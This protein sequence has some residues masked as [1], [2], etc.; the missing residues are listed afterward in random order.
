MLIANKLGVGVLMA[1]A[2]LGAQAEE[3]LVLSAAAVK[4]SIQG[5]PALL[6]AQ[7]PDS[8]QLRFGTAGAMRDEAI[9]GAAFDI[10]VVPPPAM[11]E[12]VKR[13]LVDPATQRPLGAVRLAAGLAAGRPVP[14]LSDLEAFKRSLL[15][16]N[17]VGIADP[18]KGAT[19]GIYLA[20]LFD[21]LG[22]AE[23]MKTRLRFYPEG[24]LAMEAA[25]A[26]EIDMA[27]GQMSEGSTVPGLSPLALLPDAVQLRTVYVA[28]LAQ[29]AP[30]PQTARKAMDLMLSP[31]VQQTFRRNGFDAVAQP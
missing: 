13:G 30:H 8:A 1:L 27:I 25:A 9:A 6:A 21:K 14:D 23:A 18:A 20:G 26:K 24:Q 7:G 5:V 2:A 15:Q 3:V 10:V 28:A 17:S 4:T 19:T 16:A 22:L 31:A 29:R 11:A 12:L